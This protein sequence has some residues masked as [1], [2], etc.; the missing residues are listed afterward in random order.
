MQ[1]KFRFRIFGNGKVAVGKYNVIET[2]WVT[3]SEKAVG[4]TMDPR[5]Y[6]NEMQIFQFET[7]N[8][9]SSTQNQDGSSIQIRSESISFS[10]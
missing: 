3:A 10:F 6:L 9:D 5:R 2:G 8:Y 7:L 4:Y 1:F